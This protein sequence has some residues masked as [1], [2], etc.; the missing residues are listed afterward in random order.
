MRRL[1]VDRREA[2]AQARSMRLGTSPRVWLGALSW[3]VRGLFATEANRRVAFMARELWQPAEIEARRGAARDLAAELL[4]ELRIDPEKGFRMLPASA[5]PDL[6]EVCEIGRTIIDDAS[7]D[8]G[9]ANGNKR[10]SR[11]RLAQ[12]DQ[13]LALLRVGL[14]RRLLAMAAAH[15]G[16][17][18]VIAEADFYCSFPTDGTFTKSQLWHCDDDAGDV[19]KVFVYCEDVA[20]ANGPF[21]L[22][23]TRQARQVRD[24][25]GY[26]YAGRRYR[27]PDEVMDRHVASDQQVTLLGASGTSFVVDTVR[28]FHRGSRIVDKDRRRVVGMICYCPPSG[29]T[30]PRRL[31]RGKAP[32]ASFASSFPG[33]LEH[34]VLGAPIAKKWI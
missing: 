23:P 6:A 10:F 20:E 29:R 28:C 25:V 32:L 9:E 27:V 33:D 7:L 8:T 14:D 21:E 34:A 16:I 11:F 31:A 26:R 13:R 24:A 30:L 19:L 22:V 3:H 1:T 2:A 5:M 4:P 17:L 18:P 15:L 12:A